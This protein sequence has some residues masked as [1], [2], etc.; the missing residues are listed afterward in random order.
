[1][2]LE[3]PVGPIAYRL[4]DTGALASL[5]FGEGDCASPVLNRQIEDFFDRRRRDFD[6]PLAPRGTEFQ[7]AVWRQLL[8]IPCGETRT[9]RQI[10][11]ALGSP[12]ATRAVGAANGANPIALVIPCHRVIGADG[13]LT[14]YGGGLDLKARLLDFELGSLFA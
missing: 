14:G 8:R 10:A 6:F 13:R 12:T 1:M 2:A 3:T 4:N 11:E 5:W 7:Q 9:Y